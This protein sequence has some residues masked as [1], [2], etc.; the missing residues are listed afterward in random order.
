M[1]PRKD[2]RNAV[3][4]YRRGYSIAQVASFHGVSRQ[5]MHKILQ[6]RGVIF[7]PASAPRKALP[8]E[9]RA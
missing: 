5:A 1:A 2:Y 3:R 7:R 8:A 4:Q 6:R 9:V